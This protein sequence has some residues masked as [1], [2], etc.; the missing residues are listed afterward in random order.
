MDALQLREQ[1]YILLFR[2]S[3]ADPDTPAGEN[4]KD[5]QNAPDENHALSL[6]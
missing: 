1:G 5:D 3:G 6:L 4:G 2:R